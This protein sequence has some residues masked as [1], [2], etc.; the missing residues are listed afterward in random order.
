MQK[1]CSRSSHP[2]ATCE[3]RCMHRLS[4]FFFL[5]KNG[6]SR[7]VPSVLAFAIVPPVFSLSGYLWKAKRNDPKSGMPSLLAPTGTGYVRGHSS[8]KGNTRVRHYKK[9]Q[10][11][12]IKHLDSPRL[13][14]Q[15]LFRSVVLPA[16]CVSLRSLIAPRLAS[17]L[18]LTMAQLLGPGQWK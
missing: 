6:L 13:I 14:L 17:V 9:R 16:C 15:F 3:V 2:A 10:R 4:C 1:F 5:Y 8:T 12:S 11:T 18:I 7:A